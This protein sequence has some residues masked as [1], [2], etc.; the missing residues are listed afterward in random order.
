[1]KKMEYPEQR[2][3]IRRF[4]IPRSAKQMNHKTHEAAPAVVLRTET[5]QPS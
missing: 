3:Q 4:I 1:M 2:Y 5:L